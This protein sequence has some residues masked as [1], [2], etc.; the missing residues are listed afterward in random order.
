LDSDTE[1]RPD[2]EEVMHKRT[3]DLVGLAFWI[4]ITFG[5]A[6]FASQF[7]PGGWYRTIAKPYWT[8][9][10]W[11]FGPV[12]G[13]L[14]LAM[15]ISAWLVWRQRL[16]FKAGVPLTLYLV[17]LALNGLWSWLFFGRQLIGTALIDLIVLVLLI[18]LTTAMFMRIRRAAGIMMIAYLLWVSF[19]TALNFQIWRIN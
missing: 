19:A 17:Q 18:A 10:G 16:T 8:P 12:W 7:E 5:V 4:V 14:Y 13:M 11:L 1:K 6:A 9:P 15:S 3:T 2:L